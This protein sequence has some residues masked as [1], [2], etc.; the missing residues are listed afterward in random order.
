M[1]A[2]RKGQ[3]GKRVSKAGRRPKAKHLLKGSMITVRLTAELLNLID[4]ELDYLYEERH[5]ERVTRAQGI[6]AL[7]RAG[8]D[9]RRQGRGEE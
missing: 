8:L 4:E 1:P 2:R 7:I 9:A 6:R 5:G 3:K